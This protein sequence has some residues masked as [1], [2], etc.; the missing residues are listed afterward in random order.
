M[1]GYVIGLFFASIIFFFSFFIFSKMHY[2]H[3][4]KIKYDI[5]NMF[6]YEHNFKS[7]FFDNAL[8]NMCF[9]FFGLTTVSF[10]ILALQEGFVIRQTYI[11]FIAAILHL[12]ASIL[13][14]FIPLERIKL[15]LFISLFSIVFSFPL[16]GAV[17]FIALKEYQDFRSI[18]DLVIGII[19][20]ILCIA[21]FF[22]SMNPNLNKQINYETVKN[23][24]G[25][26]TYKRPK[27]ITLAFTEWLSI[28]A[29]I[30]SSFLVLLFYLI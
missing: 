12:L 14:V 15:H 25:T 26:V 23:E 16:F 27:Y 1:D 20:I 24:D 9:V 11:L 21:Y 17:A 5:R 6:P 28:F 3:K 29:T 8:G 22:I 2:Q 4:Y 30:L 18:V 13:V 10:Y 7:G 19:A